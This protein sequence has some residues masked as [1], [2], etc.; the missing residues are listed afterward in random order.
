MKPEVTVGDSPVVLAQPHC[1][2]EIPD[3]ILKRLNFEGQARAD[4]DWHISRLYADLLANAGGK[5]P[6]GHET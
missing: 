4:T 3:A 6:V 1:G 5:L 2:I